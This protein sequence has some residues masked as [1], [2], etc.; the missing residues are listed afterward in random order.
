[1]RRIHYLSPNPESLVEALNV[2]SVKGIVQGDDAQGFNQ[3]LSDEPA[4]ARVFEVTR[5]GAG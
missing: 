4:I 5:K 3:R 2:V 1:M